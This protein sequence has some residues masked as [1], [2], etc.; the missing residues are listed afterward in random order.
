MATKDDEYWHGIMHALGDEFIAKGEHMMAF[1]ILSKHDG[2]EWIKAGKEVKA[3]ADQALKTNT[4]AER[5][6]RN[7]S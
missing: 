5:L 3:T 6:V 2:E 1:P 4:T 7:K